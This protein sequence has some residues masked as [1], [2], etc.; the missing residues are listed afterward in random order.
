MSRTSPGDSKAQDNKQAANW[1]HYKRPALGGT[2]EMGG[3][4]GE[5]GRGEAQGLGLSATEGPLASLVVG[6]LQG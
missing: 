5:R 2:L 3:G 4:Q 6:G 1:R